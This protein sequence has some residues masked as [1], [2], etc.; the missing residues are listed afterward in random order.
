MP[1]DSEED[2]PQIREWRK[3]VESAVDGGLLSRRDVEW[4][5]S[6]PP[7]RIAYYPILGAVLG[8]TATGI[9]SR[10]RLSSTLRTWSYTRTVTAAAVGA[11]AGFWTGSWLQRRSLRRFE[12]NTDSPT[13]AKI[14][15]LKRE[16]AHARD[17]IERAKQQVLGDRNLTDQEQQTIEEG[18]EVMN[19][20]ID[21]AIE[22]VLLATLIPEDV[23]V[24][25][26]SND[27]IRLAIRS[28]VEE[29]IEDEGLDLS[30]HDIEL[31]VDHEIRHWKDRPI[32]RASDP[33]YPSLIGTGALGIYGRL[34]RKP[35]IRLRWLSL[36]FIP[37][38]LA[39]FLYGVGFG[40][41]GGNEPP[42]DWLVLQVAGME[43][44]DTLAAKIAINRA[45][46]SVH[47]ALSRES[48]DDLLSKSALLLR[49][50]S[51]SGARINFSYPAERITILE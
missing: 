49:S 17:D 12:Q 6:E 51:N 44:R 37:I 42:D 47:S 36:P 7:A 30:E 41:F 38:Y 34:L 14:A 19:K 35:P 26:A 33:L 29:T 45:R 10:L 11:G 16:H 9:A 22:D 48:D 5:G 32:E 2:A 27:E 3:W 8:L 39:S 1:R 46:V 15:K 4:I 43:V 40:T 50:A 23:Q 18:M 25:G 24:H 31:L 28:I 20:T 13:L 21:S